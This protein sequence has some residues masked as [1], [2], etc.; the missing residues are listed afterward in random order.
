[1][2]KTNTI[3]RRNFLKGAAYTSALSLGGLST[4]ALAGSANV[5]PTVDSGMITLV[6]QSS[7]TVVLDAK[8]PISLE[9]KNGWVVVNVNKATNAGSV[10]PL[11]LDAGQKLSFAVENGVAPTL[12]SNDQRHGI[13]STVFV[14]EDDLPA[15]LYH[16]AF[17]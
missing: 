3:S 10:Q 4:A 9:D 1:M 17:V 13:N 15:S 7:K 5:M 8:Q 11:N 12:V 16:A 6:N 14:G 2:S